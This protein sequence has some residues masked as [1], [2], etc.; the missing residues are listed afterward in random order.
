MLS[1]KNGELVNC[2]FRVL[3]DIKLKD[4]VEFDKLICKLNKE[5]GLNSEGKFLA[6]LH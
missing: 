1:V 3:W 4:F 5:E 2:Q 6:K